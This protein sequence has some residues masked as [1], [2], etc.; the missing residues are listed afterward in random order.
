MTVPSPIGLSVSGHSSTAGPGSY[1]EGCFPG[2][3]NPETATHG[4]RGLESPC[5]VSARSRTDRRPVLCL[6]I[7]DPAP[8]RR[9]DRRAER[10][11]TTKQ[12]ATLENTPICVA[13]SQTP[14]DAR[15]VIGSGGWACCAACSWS[16]CL[17]TPGVSPPVPTP[18]LAP[19]AVD[20]AE[21]LFVRP[22][23]RRPRG[24]ASVNE[25]DS[26]ENP[27]DHDKQFSTETGRREGVAPVHARAPS[28]AFSKT[29]A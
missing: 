4:D 17:G 24:G 13:T 18:V 14:Q 25:L 6:V 23:D 5:P 7:I 26:H 15:L 27:H 8:I 3:K 2:S 11:A 10:E 9:G 29:A 1:R 19:L 12:C 22:R 16:W 20:Q 21:S 28:T